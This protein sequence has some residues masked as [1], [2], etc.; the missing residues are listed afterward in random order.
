MKL[1]SN[2]II[3]HFSFADSVH[4]LSQMFYINSKKDLNFEENFKT[5][6][7]YLTNGGRTGLEL[8]IK[9]FK[10]DKNKYIALP[11]FICGVVATPFLSRGYKIKWIDVDENGLIDVNDFEKK[12]KNIGLVV[13]PHIF[14]QKAPLKEICNIAKK[15]NILV[16]EDGAHLISKLE[17]KKESQKNPEKIFFDAQILSFGREKVLSCVSGGALILPKN[18]K[19]KSAVEKNYKKFKYPHKSWILKHLIQ[20]YIFALGINFWHFGGKIIPFLAQKLN[21]LPL[22]VTPQEKKG[23][24]DF[25]FGR[26]PIPQQKILKRQFELFNVRKELRK[27]NAKHWKKT[28]KYLFPDM[29]IIIPENYFRVILISKNFEDSKNNKNFITRKVFLK[30]LRK[31]NF[32]LNEWEGFPIAPEV[33]VKKFGYSLGSCPNAETFSQSYKTFPTHFRVNKSTVKYFAKIWKKC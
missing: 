2:Q 32:H 27:Q 33:E 23:K 20:P 7:Y 11:A 30:K 5:K 19:F 21:L 29:K 3:P 26:M 14:G 12:I 10:P 13:V 31:T 9:S 24:E 1:I 15:K 17:L 25:F 18:S 8:I 6:N 28:L 4:A 22:A 16:I